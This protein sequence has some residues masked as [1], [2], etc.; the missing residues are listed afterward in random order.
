LA[1]LTRWLALA[2][3][4]VLY[5]SGWSGIDPEPTRALGTSPGVLVFVF[6]NVL[7]PSAWVLL[8]ALG[9]LVASFFFRRPFCRTLCPIG[10]TSSVFHLIDARMLARRHR[11]SPTSEDSL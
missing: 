2:A 5:W 1:T 3:V 7:A 4:V 6:K 8:I 10:A 11:V 9:L